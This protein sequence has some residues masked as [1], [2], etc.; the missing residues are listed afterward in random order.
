MHLEQ[1]RSRILWT[2][3]VLV[4]LVYWLG[5]LARSGIAFEELTT[6]PKP[7]IV[8]TKG[9]FS[10]L[11]A[12]SVLAASRGGASRLIALALAVSAV[13]DMLL[14]TVGSVAGGAAFALAHVIA[15]GAYAAHR[16]TTARTPRWLAAAAVP[17]IAVAL[18]WL[19]LRGT[20]QPP[21]MA[22]FPLI[23]GGMAALAILSRFPLWLSGL[24]AAIFVISDVLFL[25]DLGILHRSGALGYLTWASY[26]VGYAM[27]AVGA[28]RGIDDRG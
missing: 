24:G 7:F 5:A 15:G 25:A 13:G 28:A 8:A 17:L 14:V 23:S 11:L 22:L 12:L 9:T 19:V 1:R 27:V 16:D 21:A 18:S 6:I 3:A 26:A 10:L 20:D 4:G 2:A